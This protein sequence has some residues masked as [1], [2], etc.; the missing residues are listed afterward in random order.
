[1]KKQVTPIQEPSLL[2]E[3]HRQR[4]CHQWLQQDACSLRKK[5]R[6]DDMP[7]IAYFLQQQTKQDIQE[8]AENSGIP[9]QTSKKGKDNS[10]SFERLAA[11]YNTTLAGSLSQPDA[12]FTQEQDKYQ[13]INTPTAQNADFWQAFYAQQ[14]DDTWHNP[15]PLSPQAI[16][17]L[18]PP[19]S[20]KDKDIERDSTTSETLSNASDEL[21]TT[22]LLPPSQRTSRQADP[23]ETT[24]EVKSQTLTGMS[25]I[26][27]KFLFL[28]CMQLA[29]LQLPSTKNPSHSITTL[30]EAKT[31]YQQHSKEIQ[32]IL[33]V[34][35][36]L[37]DMPVLRNHVRT[38]T[39]DSDGKTI[40]TLDRSAAYG[41]EKHEDATTAKKL[42]LS[43]LHKWKNEDTNPD[44]EFL[45]LTVVQTDSF[46]RRIASNNI[47]A[48]QAIQ[49]DCERWQALNKK[50]EQEGLPEEE[51]TA[52]MQEI[53][54]LQDDYGTFVDCLT[55]SPD[56]IRYGNVRQRLTPSPLLNW[57]WENIINPIS[58]GIMGVFYPLPTYD[59]AETLTSFLLQK[60]E[61]KIELA[62]DQVK[63]DTNENRQDPQAQLTNLT[64]QKA[65]FTKL[66]TSPSDPA[67]QSA[68][69]IV[70]AE[71]CDVH[72]N[73]TCKSGKDRTGCISA[74]ASSLRTVLDQE[75]RKQPSE[76]LVG[77]AILRSWNQ[78]FSDAQTLSVQA[79]LSGQNS[80]CA[81]GIKSWTSIL[82][83]D[84]EKNPGLDEKGELQETLA[85]A[86]V[87]ASNNRFTFPKPKNYQAWLANTT[88]D[89]HLAVSASQS[90]THRVVSSD[91]PHEPSLT[92]TFNPIH[93][94]AQEKQ[95]GPSDET[96]LSVSDEVKAIIEKEQQKNRPKK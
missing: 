65:L 41:S 23:L 94:K 12:R 83:F 59:S 54:Q 39:Q 60:L 63:S 75:E 40:L 22:R 1:M 91:M 14:S 51:K 80:C 20:R 11:L 89:G 32:T 87:L 58:R 95:R 88:A 55:I 28:R 10:I 77:T 37:S 66:L 42:M 3:E 62:Q 53:Q 49:Q 90:S 34:L 7:Y 64:L 61:K 74:L 13:Q 5:F 2:Q 33:P 19:L 84:R 43:M 50:S 82:D 38:T 35:S 18:N 17:S 24:P 6:L 27:E 72:V 36:A 79:Q 92:K 93:V 15:V 56:K 48:L 73:L 85:F 30:K 52:I 21:E 76:K 69:L 16:A 31:F 29:A 96:G 67:H 70:L 78:H 57:I 9:Y 44:A 86:E 45:F 71:L 8:W 47:L 25:E 81:R 46:E 26:E 4:A 68:A